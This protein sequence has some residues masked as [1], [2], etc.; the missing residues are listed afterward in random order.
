MN[1]RTTM[2]H[3]LPPEPPPDAHVQATLSGTPSVAIKGLFLLALF[4]TFFF[5]R[6]L[7]LPVVL[8]V[9]LSLILY[10]AV[11]CLKRL[12]LPEPVGAAIVVASLAT[13]VGAALYQL[14]EPANEW[15]AKLPRTTEQIERK[16][17]NVRKS[18]E[19]VSKAAEKVEALA[20]VD[21][22]AKQRTPQVVAREPSLMSRVLT[23]TQ[24][25]VVSV[26]AT[27]V[28]L[29]FLLASGDLFMRKLV[30]VLPTLNDKKKAV[31]LGRT[32]QSAIA[33]YLFTITCI[34]VGLGAI[35]ALI[36]HTLG[37]P[38]PVLWGAMVALLQYVPYI[39]PAI[40]GTVLTVVAFI[41]YEDLHSI[42]L[43]PFS[44]FTLVMIEGQFVTPF[45]TG[46]SLTL[47]PVMVF[48]SMLLWGW[49]W[50]V[51]GALM[52]VPILVT[53][54]IC[55]DHIES[56]HAIGEFVSG[57]PTSADAVVDQ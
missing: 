48:L 14:F 20:T 17:F 41:T 13:L 54:K 15:I 29:F 19:Q 36:M 28:L 26:G 57:K 8:A 33:R 49:I 27:L 52:A 4:Y 40:S 56:L 38:N 3:L 5:A 21:G 12:Y 42:V 6:S 24:S 43:V 32:I 46:R 39:G 7:L 53:L 50:G 47:N 11:R 30:R 16:L 45:L 51:V 2:D 9:L 55:C 22:T 34:N 31:A 1:K 37:M 25:A 23:G 44:F 35:T 10:P 18:M